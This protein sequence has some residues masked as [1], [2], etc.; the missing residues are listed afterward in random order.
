MDKS[1]DRPAPGFTELAARYKK[2]IAA[3]IT[4]VIVGLVAR[5]GLELDFNTTLA[6]VS[7]V[8]GAVVIRVRNKVRLDPETL[9][10]A[11]EVLA[12]LREAQDTTL[13]EPPCRENSG[14]IDG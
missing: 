1:P 5:Y 13:E 10:L 4:P 12:S 14:G 8:T 6:V 9:E 2:G 7:L 11:R 3:A